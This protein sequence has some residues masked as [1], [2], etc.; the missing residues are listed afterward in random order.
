MTSYLDTSNSL[1]SDRN[2]LMNHYRELLQ[3]K[4]EHKILHISCWQLSSRSNVQNVKMQWLQRYSTRYVIGLLLLLVSLFLT[5]D[6]RAAQF[7]VKYA[8]LIRVKYPNLKRLQLF[9]KVK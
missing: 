8:K 1:I 3:D 2:K 6:N 9:D 5:M 4:T 7:T